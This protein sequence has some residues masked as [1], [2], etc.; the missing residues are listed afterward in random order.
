MTRWLTFYGIW[1]E[2][3]LPRFLAMKAATESWLI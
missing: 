2:F 3:G 1:R